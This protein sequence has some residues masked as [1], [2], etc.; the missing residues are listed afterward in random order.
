MFTRAPKY[1]AALTIKHILAQ[2]PAGKQDLSP[3]ARIDETSSRRS[4][5]D[6]K[7]PGSGVRGDL[8]AGQQAMMI[9]MAKTQTM[10]IRTRQ[11]LEEA[12]DRMRDAGWKLVRKEPAKSQPGGTILTFE[13]EEDNLPTPDSFGF[14]QDPNVP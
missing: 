2:K 11:E 4:A 3:N 5:V 9:S 8:S 1:L 14:P 10:L 7:I 12:I 13:E 6:P